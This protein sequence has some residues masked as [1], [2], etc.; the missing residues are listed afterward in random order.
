MI[1]VPAYVALDLST[2]CYCHLNTNLTMCYFVF[3]SY[4]KL[5]EDYA[6]NFNHVFKVCDRII[7]L[8][9]QNKRM[10]LEDLWYVSYVNYNKYFRFQCFKFNNLFIFSN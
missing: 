10:K 1:N 8:S 9:Q 6:N 5:N 3:I 4:T 7:T 2:I